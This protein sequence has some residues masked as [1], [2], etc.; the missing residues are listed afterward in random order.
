[1][2][3]RRAV[4][5]LLVAGGA[6][7]RRFYE[8][9]RD[10]APSIGPFYTAALPAPDEFLTFDLDADTSP[11][12][13]VSLHCI[14]CGTP[15]TVIVREGPEIHLRCPAGCSGRIF[16]ESIQMPAEAAT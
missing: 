6:G 1:M 8:A 15:W 3:T 12:V 13:R 7:L 4:L 5:G 2:L 11:A 9:L 14:D 10:S 16:V